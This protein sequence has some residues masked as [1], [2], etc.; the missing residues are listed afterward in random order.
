VKA[1]AKLGTKPLRRMDEREMDFK[2]SQ[3]S[4]QTL[5]KGTGMV[6]ETSVICNH[7]KRLIDWAEFIT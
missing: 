4:H 6:L 2:L 1:D 7:L 3:P 5:K